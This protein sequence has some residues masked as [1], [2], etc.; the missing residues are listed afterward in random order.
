MERQRER[1]KESRREGKRDVPNRSER[2]K[3]TCK[4]VKGE[5][6]T[7]GEKLERE[8]RKRREKE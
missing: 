8:A 2:E 3:S 6:R 5:R 7:L 1:E 4:R